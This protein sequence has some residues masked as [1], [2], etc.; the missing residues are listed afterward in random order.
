MKILS[1]RQLKELDRYTIEHEPIASVD[2]MERAS[3]AV[4]AEIAARWTTERRIVLFAGPGN[5]GG[6]ALAVAR[7]LAQRGYSTYTYLFNIKGALSEDCLVN[8]DRLAATEGAEWT[9]ITSQFDFPHLSPEHDVIVDGLFGTGLNKPLTGGY[10]MVARMINDAR[11]PVV[12]ID[13]PS[14]LMCEDNAYNNMQHVVQ[15]TLTL[16]MQVPKLAFLFAENQRYTG[17]WKALDIGLSAEGIAQAG[18]HLSVTEEAEIKALL[19]SR[20]PFA[21]KGTMGHALLVSGCYGM[22][23][24][25]ILASQ[26]CLR[27]G[28][29]KLTLHTPQK[30]LPILQT[31]VP[32]AIVSP[33]TDGDIVT[34]AIGTSAFRAVGAGP[35]LGTEEETATA[36]YDFILQQNEPMVLD[37]DALTLLGRHPEWMQRLPNES[38][39]T[40]HP[41][42]L[43]ALTGPCS[44]SCERMNKALDLAV[45]HNLYVLVKGHYTQICTP[46][47]AVWFNPTGNAGMA[48]AGSG[49]VLTGL[50]TGLLAQGY[51][52]AHAVRLGV[53][54]HGLAGDIAAE[55]LG[56]NCMLASDLIDALPQAFKQLRK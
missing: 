16:T 4:A 8:R 33:D 53:W 18:S 20:N 44:D 22:A 3:E 46:T 28:I 41:K 23:G 27:S 26:A 52:P 5:N 12:S 30:N 13:I 38:I 56:Q 34:H 15:A 47:G 35:G 43:E 51:P 24:A 48:T 50:L 2:L 19:Q 32:E 37:A 1:A 31:A 7:L 21:H 55:R 9:E 25:A 39:L 10:A 40:P 29:G 36:L 17:E 42:E 49:D 45:R 14:G 11:V 6:D 54:L